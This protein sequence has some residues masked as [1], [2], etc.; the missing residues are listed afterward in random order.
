MERKRMVV[1]E[2]NSPVWWLVHMGGTGL[3]VLCPKK[4]KNN[5]AV[6]RETKRD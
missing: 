3:H 1:K 5:T 4:A 2:Q 6:S